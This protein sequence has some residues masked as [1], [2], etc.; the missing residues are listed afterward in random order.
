M[1]NERDSYHSLDSD[2]E[3]SLLLMKICSQKYRSGSRLVGYHTHIIRALT[4]HML[5][6]AGF[7]LYPMYV[8]FA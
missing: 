1:A 3:G 6:S 8:P 5:I 7:L 2:Q 4:Q